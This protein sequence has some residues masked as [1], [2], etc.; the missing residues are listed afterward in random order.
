M[1]YI[2][3]IE[4]ATDVCS[5]CISDNDKILAVQQ[6]VSNHASQIT[7]MIEKCLLEAHL[8]MKN[9][10]AIAISNTKRPA[11]LGVQGDIGTM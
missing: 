10:D 2:L 5:I 11:S 1:A 7:M 9:L 8:K 3:N 4:S 6:T